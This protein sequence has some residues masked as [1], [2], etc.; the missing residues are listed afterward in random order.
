LSYTALG[1]TVFWHAFFALIQSI[2]V[3]GVLYANLSAVIIKSV[4]R[5]KSGNASCMF[6]NSYY[7]HAAFAADLV[8]WLKDISDWTTAGMAVSFGFAAISVILLV[9]AYTIQESAA[10]RARKPAELSAPEA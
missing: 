7:I 8:G 4:N 9:I 5:D 1:G 6:V 3:I 10:A 2:A